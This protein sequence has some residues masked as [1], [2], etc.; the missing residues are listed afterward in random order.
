MSNY[1]YKKNNQSRSYL[2]QLVCS[3]FWGPGS[4]VCIAIDYWLDG[5]G[6]LSRWGEIFRPSRTGPGA[7]TASYTMGIWSFSGVKYDGAVLLTTHLLLVARS[8]N[9]RAI[10]LPT[11]WATTR[12]IMGTLY[13]YIYMYIFG[14]RCYNTKVCFIISEQVHCPHCIWRTACTIILI[15]NVCTKYS[16]N[17]FTYQRFFLYI[18]F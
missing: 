17:M 2:N 7:Q 14:V 1:G 3:F 18:Y 12:P 10:Y 5:S 15:Q 6:I 4:S 16:Q 8:W 13:L 11:I 9:S